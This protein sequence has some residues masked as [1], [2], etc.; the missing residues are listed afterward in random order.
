LILQV[1]VAIKLLAQ[2]LSNEFKFWLDVFLVNI[3]K[4]VLKN[5]VMTLSRK[6]SSIPL[7]KQSFSDD[8]LENSKKKAEEEKRIAL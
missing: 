4:F 5:S 1:Q 8:F 6:N 3:I 2:A 7:S